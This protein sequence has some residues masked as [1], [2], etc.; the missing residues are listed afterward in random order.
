MA[1]VEGHFKSE[2]ALGR[3]SAF[4]TKLINKGEKIS[5]D[6]FR[7]VRPEV[8]IPADV[9]QQLIGKTLNKPLAKG[10]PITWD[11]LE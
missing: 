1:L 9:N 8:G 2:E 5:K 11:D 7:F 3:R 4:T 6:N 10:V